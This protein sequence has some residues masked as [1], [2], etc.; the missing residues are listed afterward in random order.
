MKPEDIVRAIIKEQ[1]LIIGEQLAKQMA[2]D[3][4]VV[5]FN[6]SKLEDI[7][8][9][10]KD[11]GTAIDRVIN[12]YRNLFGQASVDVCLNVIRKLP[13]GNVNQLLSDSIKT[14]L[15]GSK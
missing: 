13:D 7:S 15:A 1:S 6:S 11:S 4:G 9:T 8:V 14:K 10:S 3:S 2:T 5:R 12:S